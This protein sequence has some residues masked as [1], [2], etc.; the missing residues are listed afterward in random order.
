LGIFDAFF[1]FYRVV[2]R[3][4]YRVTFRVVLRVV[5]EVK[6]ILKNGT[7]NG[8][9]YQHKEAP[10]QAQNPNRAFH[11][12]ACTISILFYPNLSKIKH[13]ERKRL[14]EK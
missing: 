1:H 8:F 12:V 7:K 3:V 4:V 14:S 2:Y 10:N 13:G 11:P 9:F 6:I 5:S